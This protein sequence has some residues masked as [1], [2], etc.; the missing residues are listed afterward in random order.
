MVGIKNFLSKVEKLKLKVT[1]IA[2]PEYFVK[3]STKDPKKEQKDFE[4]KLRK[5]I[6][7]SD[8]EAKYEILKAWLSDNFKHSRMKFGLASAWF[9]DNLPAN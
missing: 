8:L 1:Y 5:L 6:E 3:F 7:K 9:R 2:A 4:D